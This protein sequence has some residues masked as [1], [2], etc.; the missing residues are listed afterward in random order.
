MKG[1]SKKKRVS[2]WLA[3]GITVV[4]C[5]A[6]S[7]EVQASV[8]RTKV[9]EFANVL[10]V[11]ASP[12]ERTNGVYDTNYFNNFSDLGAWHGYYLPEKSNK[13]LLGG[14]AGPLIIAEEYPVNLAA[15]LNKLTVKNKKTGETYD[16]SQSNRMDL[17]YYPGRLEQIYELDDLTIHLALIFVSNRTALIQTTLENTGEEPLSLEASWTGAVFDKIQEGTETLD[18]GTRLTAK[19]ND[20]QVNFGEVRETWNYFATKDTKYTIHHADKVSTKIDNR[21]YTATAEPIE[22]K[23]KQTYNT[24]TTESYTFTKE[25]E[26]KEQQQAPEYTKNARAISK[27]TSK[28][29]KDI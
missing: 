20:I 19:D 9:D 2:T 21:N 18:I 10:D 27:R 15:S 22:L 7:G 1:L 24:Y 28:D 6:L 16:L 29:G 4:S 8:E 17:S 5:F 11:S 13:E 12:T 23:P 25:E 14:F 26:A 3:L